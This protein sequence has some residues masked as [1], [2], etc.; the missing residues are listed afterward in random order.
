MCGRINLRTSPRAW[1][2]RFLPDLN[3]ENLPTEFSTEFQPRYNIAPTQSVVVVMN[4]PE[5]G[6]RRLDRLSWGLIPPWADELS[7]GARMINAR[8]ETVDEKPSFKKALTARRCL[9]IA[10]GY[11][12]WKKMDD[13]KQ[14]F[15]IEPSDRKSV[16]VMAGLWE[17]NRKV[18]GDGSALRTCTILTTD[19]NA[20]T[21]DI[22]HRM[23]VMM[24]DDQVDVWLDPKVVDPIALKNLLVP[25]PDQWLSVRPVDRH[26][27]NA[28]NDDPKC[29]ASPDQTQ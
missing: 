15:V 4:D 11:Y 25:A 7:I 12:E 14:P 6:T 1:V 23:P 26:V 19:A 17:S 20:T 22:H 2:Q 3:P 9:V 16:L 29:L 10:D 27:N 5:T 13:G 21:A 24:A 28:R 8:S 18:T